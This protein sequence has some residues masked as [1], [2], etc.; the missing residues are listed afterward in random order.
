MKIKEKPIW[1]FRT[2]ATAQS[3]TRSVASSR[4]F[5]TVIDEPIERGGTNEGPMP[6][7]LVFAGLAGCT[8]VI[9]NKLATHHGISFDSMEINIRTTMDSRGTRLIEPIDVPFPEVV[10]NIAVETSGP[11]A[12]VERVMAD[13]RHHCAVSKMLQQSGS[14]VVERWTVN[15]AA[16][17]VL[18]MT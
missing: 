18:E 7:E 15:G 13:L 1:N 6:V 4:T 16:Q 12:A 2:A 8:H 10:I 9:A 17:P 11:Q 3:T 14:Q 5:D